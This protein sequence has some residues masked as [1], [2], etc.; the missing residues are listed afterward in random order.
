M[1]TFGIV[2]IT[3]V[4]LSSCAS[5][6]ETYTI[7]IIDGVKHVHNTAPKWGDEQKINLEFIQKIG[8]LETEDENYMLFKPYDVERDSEGNIYIVEQGNCRIQK[9]NAAGEYLLKMG[10]KGEGPGEFFRPGHLSIVGDSVIYVFEIPLHQRV[11]TFFTDGRYRKTVRVNSMFQKMR[12]QSNG[13]LVGQPF[14]AAIKML[15][16]N[17]DTD[18]GLINIYDSN[19]ERI[20]ITGSIPEFPVK[21]AKGVESFVSEISLEIDKHDNII[22]SFRILNRLEKYTA[23]GELS[24]VITRPLGFDIHLVEVDQ[25]LAIVEITSGTGVDHKN[26][27]WSATFKRAPEPNEKNY[28]RGENLSRDMHFEIFSG[29]GVLLGYI[30]VPVYFRFMRIRDDRLY[31]IDAFTDMCVYEY[32]IIE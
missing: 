9:Y 11:E 1:K 22:A 17:D 13:N 23:T 27:I 5:P 18:Y 15:N 25:G 8:E 7:E 3:I 31:L 4:I 6:P 12:A 14:T 2:L 29:D 32:K 20:K 26:R 16:K 21:D 28:G 24:H 30:P 19:G 10:S